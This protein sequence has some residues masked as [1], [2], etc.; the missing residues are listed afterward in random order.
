MVSSRATTMAS[1]FSNAEETSLGA[2]YNC[3]AALVAM[4]MSHSDFCAAD[5]K[6]YQRSSLAVNSFLSRYQGRYLREWTS[7]QVPKGAS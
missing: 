6:Q 7:S 1:I 4:V 2:L 3:S 5:G